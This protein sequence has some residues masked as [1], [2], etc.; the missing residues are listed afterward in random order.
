MSIVYK[1]S[2]V[3]LCKLFSEYAQTIGRFVKR[4]YIACKKRV[5]YVKK[6]LNYCRKLILI[7]E[8]ILGLN[9]KDTLLRCY[10]VALL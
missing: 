7:G 1:Y 10:I 6:T 9:I 3:K 2:L 4:R 8:K 5:K